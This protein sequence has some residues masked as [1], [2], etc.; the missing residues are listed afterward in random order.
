MTTLVKRVEDY[1]KNEEDYE[2]NENDEINEK[3]I[4]NFRLF[5]HF[6]F[7]RNPLLSE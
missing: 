7:F 1:E 5:R 6:R 2:K 4:Q 3:I